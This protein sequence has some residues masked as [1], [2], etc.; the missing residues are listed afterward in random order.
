MNTNTRVGIIALLV[1]VVVI[2]FAITRNYHS[3]DMGLYGQ[4]NQQGQATTTG[5]TDYGSTNPDNTTNPPSLSQTYSQPAQSGLSGFSLRYPT[6]FTVDK[7]Y[8]YQALGP[9]KDIVGTKFT[10][11]ASMAAGTNLGSDSYISVEQIP[12]TVPKADVSVNT[13]TIIPLATTCTASLFIPNT[14][15]Q[16][17]TDAG[18]TYS[19][20]STTGA[21]AGN[22]YEETVSAI[23]GTNPCIGVRYF[24][25]YSVFENY[26]AGSIKQFNKAALIV[27]FDAIRRTLVIA[28]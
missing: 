9:G 8:H 18:V 5:S 21:G 28:R 27:V 15:P 12:L 3:G 10:I 17:V 25:H 11:P 22:R 6:G 24:V 13:T 4:G 19:V 20:S 16:T 14:K 2:A 23:P 7:S 1:S 26:P